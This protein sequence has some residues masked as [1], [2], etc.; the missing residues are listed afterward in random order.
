MEKYI[1]DTNLFFNMA[2]GFGMGQKTEETV[3]NT[4][5]F[6]L[7]LK[8]KA[9]FYMPPR[10]V[11]EFL[12][13]FEDKNQPFL[14]EFLSFVIIKAPQIEEIKFPASVFYALVDDIRQR[15]YRGL[16]LAEEQINKAGQ[17]AVERKEKLGK[18]DFEMA[19]GPF[20]KNFR[21]RYRQ[22]TRYGFL[23]SLAD[24]DLIVL[25]KEIDGFLVTSDEGVIQWARRFGVKETPPVTWKKRLE[26]LLE[27]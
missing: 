16:N 12:S 17:L 10:V 1:L 4:S 9:Q 14:K 22:A 8:D 23:D 26:R 24:L 3:K 2:A 25:A 20:I 6:I 5:N 7:K 11:D 19:I 27:S 13:F 21:E 15:S 18:K